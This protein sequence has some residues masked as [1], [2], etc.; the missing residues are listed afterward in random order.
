MKTAISAFPRGLS[1]AALLLLRVS[2]GLA[3][4]FGS[5]AAHVLPVSPHFLL[6]CVAAALAVGIFTQPVAMLAALIIA[7]TYAG[8]ANVLPFSFGLHSLVAAA[9]AL[10]GAGAYSVDA[11]LFGR[12]VIKFD[13]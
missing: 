7:A 13:K 10:M 12:R 8:S 3:L 2:T 4:N 6:L 1:G 9:L 11:I 5:D